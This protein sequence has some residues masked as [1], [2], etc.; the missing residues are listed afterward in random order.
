MNKATAVGY[1]GH[2]VVL[3]DL[4]G[5]LTS[6]GETFPSGGL[7]EEPP[8]LRRSCS[9]ALQGACHFIPKNTE[10][11]LLHRKREL[12]NYDELFRNENEEAQ[13]L[14]DA[15][16]EL[17]PSQ[18]ARYNALEAEFARTQGGFT[19]VPVVPAPNF[20]SLP[21][22]KKYTIS[23]VVKS[24]EDKSR[25]LLAKFIQSF[26]RRVNREFGGYVKRLPTN[27]EDFLAMGEY[28][29]ML[30]VLCAGDP[31]A[32]TEIF[33]FW[34]VMVFRF[35]VPTDSFVVD[36]VENLELKFLKR[37]AIIYVT[38]PK[39]PDVWSDYEEIEYDDASS[40]I[41]VISRV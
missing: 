40:V 12:K 23:F 5:L 41:S 38:N 31:R 15:G 24:R 26:F 10:E 33:E 30:G 29:V 20:Y 4:W 22:V 9:I 36:E 32:D 19:A 11:K 7:L 21:I 1:G 39:E 17:N 35:G 2:G 34:K 37:F 27:S 18:L 25:L 6:T 8:S 14:I 28:E 16:T 3:L 13:G